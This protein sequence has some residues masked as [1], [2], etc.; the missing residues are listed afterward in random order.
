MYKITLTFLFIV[1]TTGCSSL[2]GTQSTAEMEFCWER[3]MDFSWIEGF[4]AGCIDPMVDAAPIRIAKIRWLEANI[5]TLAR[6]DSFRSEDSN[7]KPT[8]H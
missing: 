8:L 1:L 4:D 2:N 7:F 3:G 5:G 6:R